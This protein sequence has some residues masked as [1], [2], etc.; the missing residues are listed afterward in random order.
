MEN[1]LFRQDEP[2]TELPVGTI[3]E[4]PRCEEFGEVFASG[5]GEVVGL[6]C[7]LHA[8]VIS[9]TNHPEYLSVCPNCGCEFGTN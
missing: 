7:A 6:Y 5:D 2:G 1:R 8:D 4:Y 9:R 3:C